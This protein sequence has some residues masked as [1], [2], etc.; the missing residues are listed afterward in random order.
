MPAGRAEQKGRHPAK[1]VYRACLHGN[2]RVFRLLSASCGCGRKSGNSPRRV[3]DVRIDLRSCFTCNNGGIRLAFVCG[4]KPYNENLKQLLITVILLLVSTVLSA[5]ATC[6]GYA[7]T[8]AF[9][10]IILAALLVGRHCAYACTAMLAVYALC[11]PVCPMLLLHISR[12][13]C[14]LLFPPAVLLR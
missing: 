1:R 13:Q 10:G 12:C 2:C 8:A 14:L 6:V 5:F 11:L 3:C 7:F 4:K 9:L